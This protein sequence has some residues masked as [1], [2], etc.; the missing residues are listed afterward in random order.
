MSTQS[1]AGEADSG[2]RVARRFTVE[3]KRD[4][5]GE[6]EWIVLE[7]GNFDEAN[8]EGKLKRRSKRQVFVSG[9]AFDAYL[10]ARTLNS[11]AEREVEASA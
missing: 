11:R 4:A 7:H 1:I 5:W 10:E 6:P 9:S 3:E 2:E 8:W